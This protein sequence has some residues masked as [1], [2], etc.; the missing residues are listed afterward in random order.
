MRKTFAPAIAIAAGL[1]IAVSAASLGSGAASAQSYPSRPV[2][3]IVPFPPGGGLDVT[4]R[5]MAPHLSEALGQPVV[6][7]NAGGAAGSI[8]VG[9]AVRSAPDGYTLSIGITSTHVFNGA[10]Y[11]IGRAHV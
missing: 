6:V 5:I 7:E 3:I 1:S 11:K 9:K 10:M 8:G 2:T 4:A